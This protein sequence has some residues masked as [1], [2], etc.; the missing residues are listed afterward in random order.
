[1]HDSLCTLGYRYWVL[2]FDLYGQQWCL[3]Y[4]LV[5]VD[6][7]RES[8]YIYLSRVP[9]VTSVINTGD[10][11][12]CWYSSSVLVMHRLA[13]WRQKEINYCYIKINL[14]WAYPSKTNAVLRYNTV[15]HWGLT[16]EPNWRE[17]SAAALK[18]LYDFLGEGGEGIRAL[19]ALSYKKTHFKRFGFLWVFCLGFFK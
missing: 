11:T 8:I 12:Q 5:A 1:M 18:K 3:I 9:S 19:V 15:Y 16:A 10:S 14:S 17:K 4:F 7:H 2:S 6:E 13:F